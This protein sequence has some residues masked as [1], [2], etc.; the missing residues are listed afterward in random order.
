MEQLTNTNN[1]TPPI[2]RSDQN[3]EERSIGAILPKYMITF[4]PGVDLYLYQGFWCPSSL[5]HNVINFQQN[6]EARK[7]DIKENGILEIKKLAEFLG[8]EFSLEEEK[9]GIIDEI[10]QLCSLNNLK[11]LEVNKTGKFM[12]KFDN[13]VFFRK[14]EVGDWVNHLSPIMVDRLEQVMN[15]K[16]SDS[17]LEFKI[18]P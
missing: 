9:Q 5:L 14:G 8:C 2:V 16:F 4:S 18:R 6:F 1:N 15:D 13:K 10:L 11:E 17:G 7:T 3:N 12:S